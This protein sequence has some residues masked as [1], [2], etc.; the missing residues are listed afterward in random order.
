M[1]KDNVVSTIA[2]GTVI[3]AF[4]RQYAVRL[5][6]GGE[7]LCYPRAKRSEIACGDRVE[8]ALNAPDQGVIDKIL[9]R[10][11]LF[12]RADQWK[13]K[14]I[15]A[16]VTQIVVVV[17]T[18]P[19]FSDELIT[20]CMVAA[21]AQD[22]AA[23][24]VL[25]KSD[26]PASLE[27]CRAQLKAFVAAG[28]A[29]L[30]MSAMGDVEPL[31]ERL[32]DHTSLFV[33]QSGMGKST[34]TNALIPDADARTREISEVLDSGK[35]TTTHARLYALPGGGQLIDSPGLQSFGLAHLTKNEIECGFPEIRPLLGT[36]RFRDCNH[37]K[38]PDCALRGARDSGEFDA[39]RYTALM[40]LLDEHEVARK[41]RLEH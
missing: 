27:A 7:A 35:H 2:Q 37:L 26:I 40:Q 10:A 22:I 23:L 32:R 13:E 5:D 25:N 8:M 38:E 3:A 1:S 6:T 17:A 14:L 20:R 12:Y 39:R 9:P 24:I 31:R 28:H 4:G 21:D 36:C 16:N 29:V 15:A 18:E 34:L 11:S 41:H 33:G 30:E 19:G